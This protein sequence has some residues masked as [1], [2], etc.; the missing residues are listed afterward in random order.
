MYLDMLQ[1]NEAIKDIGPLLPLT[2]NP[3]IRG[4]RING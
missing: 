4:I 2:D 1:N 3:N